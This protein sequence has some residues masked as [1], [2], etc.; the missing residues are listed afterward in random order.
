MEMEKGIEKIKE[1]K[2]KLQKDKFIFSKREERVRSVNKTIFLGITVFNVIFA[3]RAIADYIRG[4]S[5]QKNI[6][7]LALTL[8]STI[9]YTVIL[10]RNKK[11]EWFRYAALISFA[12]QYVYNLLVLQNEYEFITMITLMAACVLYYDIRLQA[13]VIAI[14]TTSNIIYLVILAQSSA[15]T[16]MQIANFIFMLCGFYT[17]IR[18]TNISEKFLGHALGKANH[19]HA[20]Q[21]EILKNVLEIAKKLEEDAQFSNKLLETLSASTQSINDAVEEIST[22]TSVT[23]ENIQDQTTMTSAI[24]DSINNTLGYAEK[25]VTVADESKNMIDE[26][27]ATMDILKNESEKMVTVNQDTSMSMKELVTKTDEVKN[28]TNTIYEISNQTNLLALNASIESARAGEAGR[29]FAVVADEIRQLADQTKKATESISRLIEELGE[30]SQKAQNTVSN[31]VDSMN[32]QSNRI[33]QAADRFDRL[34]S[35]I[36]ALAGHVQTLEHQ[37]EQ[38]ASANCK[39]VDSINQL[40][41]TS[42]EVSAS[43]LQAAEIGN[44]NKKDTAKTIELLQNLMNT[45]S[46]FH[47]YTQDAEE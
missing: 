45:V 4:I 2:E 23:A 19:E 28:F 33:V 41:G 35:N 9:I 47:Q 10:L 34:S 21:V 14:C 12:V 44:A 31:T 37:M 40:S 43:S 8:I 3:L 25:M 20:E 38:L 36:T 29:G 22:A 13:I 18:V 16:E 17:A 5:P 7:A 11:S 39:I 32:E 6:I 46:R 30:T 42:E 24:Q 27:L 15:L 1:L 26:N